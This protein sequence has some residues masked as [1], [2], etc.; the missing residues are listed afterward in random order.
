MKKTN[1]PECITT[2]PSGILLY[3]FTVELSCPHHR[4]IAVAR[5]TIKVTCD[6]DDEDASALLD[7]QKKPLLRF[8]ACLRDPSLHI[9]TL[10]TVF[11]V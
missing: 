11:A 6:V 2:T 5:Q 10:R 1:F 7:D 3:L 8:C 9:Y 4:L